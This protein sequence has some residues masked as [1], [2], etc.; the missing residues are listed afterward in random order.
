MRSTSAIL[1]DIEKFQPTEDGNWLALD[2][3]LEEL[4]MEDSPPEALVP[5]FQLLERFPKDESA[6]VL[7][8]VLHGIE[9]YHPHYEAELVQSL[10]RHPTDMTVTMVRRMVNSGYSLVAGQSSKSLYQA[11]LTH[12]KAS[13]E[14]KES[15]QDYLNAGK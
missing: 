6:G 4:F 9:T 7:W 10:R 3:L 1:H 13:E 2:A 12:P 11:V 8:S 5:L 14:A 15:A